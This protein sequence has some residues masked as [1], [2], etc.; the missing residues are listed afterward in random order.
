MGAQVGVYTMLPLYLTTERGMS[1]GQ[2]NTILGL[3]NIA[4]LG[5]VFLSGWITTK[6]GLRPTMTLF[7]SL[8]GLMVHPRRPALGRRAWWSASSSWPPW[9]WASSPR[10]SHRSPASSNPTIR[11]LAAGFAPPLAFLL[12]GGLLPTRWATSARSPASAWAS[13]SPAPSS[14]SDPSAT[15]LLR[16]LTNLEAGC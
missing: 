4:P 1:S 6:I 14:W 11:S 15:L 9:P 2:A 10:R 3:A 8:T 5:V 12:G 16:L 7:L 13:P